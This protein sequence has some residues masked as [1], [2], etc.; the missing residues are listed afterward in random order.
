MNALTIKIITGCAAI[1]I[2]VIAIVGLGYFRKFHPPSISVVVTT[3]EV[4][5]AADW[6]LVHRDALKVDEQRCA[7]NASN[8]SPAACQ[9][10]RDAVS[11]VDYSNFQNLLQQEKT[12]K[13]N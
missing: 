3:P 1:A 10:V 6:Y 11:E 12:S 8:I 9:N 7:G 4:I 13:N 5:H 2:G